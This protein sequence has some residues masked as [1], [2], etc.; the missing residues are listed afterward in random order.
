MANFQ[1][2]VNT[3]AVIHLTAK[4]ERLNKS[5]FPSA[6]RATLSDGAFEMKIKNIAISAGKNMTVRNKTVFKKFT[7]VERAKFN[8]NVESM[9]ATVGFIPKDGIKGSKVPEGMEKNEV[10][11]TDDDGMM[12]LPKTRV[13]GSSKRLVR[14]KSR[15]DKSKIAKGTSSFRKSKKLANI[16]NMMASAKEN[17]PTF[18][19]TSKG[20]F[21]VQVKSFGKKSNGKLNIKLDFLMRDRKYF[22]AKANATHFVK[23]A[24]QNT[25]KQME[26]FYHTNAEFQFAKVWK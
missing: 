9:S 1:F 16:Q 10:G 19:E 3:E 18:I 6:V 20:R 25:Q 14:N 5:A 24:A 13:T 22:K 4:L 11:G 15:F 8:R 23:E 26:K 7:G 2:N 12:Y 17:A 21:L